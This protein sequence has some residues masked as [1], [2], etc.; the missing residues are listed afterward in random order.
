MTDLPMTD[1]APTPP[2]QLRLQQR[3]LRL[4]Q[5]QL[6]LR[7]RL[8]RLRRWAHVVLWFERLWVAIWPALGVAGLFA[9]VAM[10]G[11]FAA[12]PGWAHGA[13]LA[14]FAMGL[15]AALAIGLRRLTRPSA[16][17][18][19]RW[20]ERAAGLSHQP[21]AALVDRPATPD[22]FARVLWQAHAQRA[23]ASLSRLRL[24]WPRPGLAARD[25]RAL[26]GL[27]MVALVAAIG[28]AGPDAWPRIVGAFTPGFELG[29]A[30]PATLLQAWVTPPAYTA[31]PPL[32]LHPD[33]PSISVPAGSRLAVSVTGSG[34]APGVQYAGQKLTPALL[35]P[36]SWQAEQVLGAGG[37]LAVRHVGRELGGW[38]IATVADAPPTA[39]FPGAPGAV[40]RS[41]D[42]RVP[43]QTG[44]D[45]GVVSLSAEIRLRDRPHAPPLK[46]EIP[47]SGTPKSARGV[48]QRDLTPH[49]WAGLPVTIV[50]SAHDAPGQEGRSDTAQLVLPERVFRNELARALVA[51]RKQ[52]SLTPE[53][54]NGASAALLL[55]G[56]QGDLYDHDP[57]ILLNMSAIAGLLRHD[58][59]PAAVDQAQARLWTLALALEENGVARTARAVEAARQAVQ[60]TLDQ[61]RQ[62]N[63]QTAQTKPGQ[64]PAGPNQAKPQDPAA[65]SKLDQQMRD[66][67]AAI[68]RHMQALAQQAMRDHTAQPFDPNAPHMTSQDIDKMLQQMQQDAQ[69]GRP[70]DAAREL[71]QLQD[72]LNKL[73]QA[74]Q[75][76]QQNAGQ[77]GQHSQSG[78][79]AQRQRGQQQMGAV[80]DMVQR[81]STLRD[82]ANGRDKPDQPQ[83][84]TQRNT[85]GRVQQAL[86]RAL[87][88]LMQQFGDLT[89]KIPDELGEA[90]QAMR[91]AGEDLASGH[92]AAAGADQ[93]KAVEALQKGG[94]QMSQQMAQQMGISIMPGQG[95]EGEGDPSAS[96]DGGLDDQMGEGTAQSTLPGQEGQN[97]GGTR[98]PLGRLTSNGASGDE[99]GDDVQLPQQMEQA[100][101]RDIQNELRRREGDRSRSQEELRYID[102]LLQ[103]E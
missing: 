46:L 11:G 26:R 23:A 103:A 73:Q 72:L 40:A 88:E 41:R 77:P 57:G 81:E 16:P 19:D 45:Y 14:A 39:R 29:A 78:R 67:R 79:N 93:Q 1:A 6:R 38:E 42:L 68:Q 85:D 52:L 90:D 47:L 63:P 61:L 64:K 59:A 97:Q 3:Q 69:A 20:L 13:L 74:E 70:A 18:A 17:E 7:Q 84:D 75:Q 99:T 49:P 80:Q 25:R 96:A 5:R 56:Q 33:H 21:L 66:L 60:Q 15:V 32:F 54:R 4:Q 55:L 34:T 76:G 8:L 35:G 87:G 101:T 30:A 48:L 98:D 2:R 91:Q 50:L 12:L 22:P 82:Q 65:L 31:L 71:A 58:H 27:L 86:R 94:Q 28:I 9:V 89:G 83:A 51:L 100:R 36:D 95:G 10:L 37:R 102:R 24:S 53:E 43:W 44:D 92:D 62:Q